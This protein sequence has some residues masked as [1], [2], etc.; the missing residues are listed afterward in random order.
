[1][2][3]EGNA[4]SDP[5]VRTGSSAGEPAPGLHRALGRILALDPQPDCVVITGDLCEYGHLDAYPELRTLIGRF[6]L[7]IH[8]T[9]GNHDDRDALLKTFGGTAFL[10]GTTTTRYTVGYPA[11]T[12]VVLDS[13]RPDSPAGLLGEEQLAWLHEM[14][15]RRP[16]TPAFVCLHHPPIAVGIP[17]LDGMRLGDGPALAAVISR[18]RNVVWVLAGH[19][20]RVICAPL[21]DGM[22][23]IA[24]STT[25]KATCACGPTA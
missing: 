11:A 18:H 6:P 19:V 23:V 3:R 20:H 24:P 21:A 8:L 22:V 2:Q 13:K 15:A 1:V 14:L 16:K 7:P 25:G 4:I 5:H 9:T 12:I 10:G 17:F